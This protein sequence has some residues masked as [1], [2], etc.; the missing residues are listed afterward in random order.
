MIFELPYAIIKALGKSPHKSSFVRSKTQHLCMNIKTKIVTALTLAVLVAPGISMAQTQSVATLQQEIASLTAQLQQFETQL[1]SAGESTTAWCYTFNNNLSVGMSGN[2]VTE[3]QTALQKNGE[4]V[5]VNGTFDDQTAAAV[6][7]FQEKYKS[8]IL[9]PYGL[10]NGTGYAG[11]STRAKLNSLFGC[12]GTTPPPPICPAWGCNGPEPVPTSSPIGV[13]CPMLVQYCPYG[14][15]DV[16]ESNGCTQEVCN[17]APTQQATPST[18]YPTG[19]TS[20]SGYSSTNGQS[21][22]SIN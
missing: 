17:Q 20:F 19:C 18:I 1:A 12:T 13:A 14:G 21:C 3:L 2:A 8:T 9:S 16:V 22:G 4:S 10:S 6:T 7:A 5:T 15:H 11:K